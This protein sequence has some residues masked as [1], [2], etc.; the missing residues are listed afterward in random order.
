M[1]SLAI[2]NAGGHEVS[3]S[4]VLAL[5][6]RAASSGARNIGISGTVIT[7]PDVSIW[8]PRRFWLS[9]F[10]VTV[11]VPRERTGSVVIAGLR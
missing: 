9:Q 5:A 1:T 4:S 3:G 11:W 2:V 10:A 7:P 8:D 6:T